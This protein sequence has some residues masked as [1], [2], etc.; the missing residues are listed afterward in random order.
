MSHRQPKF[1]VYKRADSDWGWRLQAANGEVIA[2]GEGYESAAGARRGAQTV[3]QTASEA[4]VEQT[5][6]G[7]PDDK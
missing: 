4:I 7:G 2:S 1:E 3:T 5:Q 6:T